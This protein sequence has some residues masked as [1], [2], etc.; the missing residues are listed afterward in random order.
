MKNKQSNVMH[1]IS[2]GRYV[3]KERHGRGWGEVDK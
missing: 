2:D 1:C 3:A